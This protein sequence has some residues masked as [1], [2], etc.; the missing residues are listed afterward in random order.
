ML[1]GLIALLALGLS[2]PS[3]AQNALRY[4]RAGG[5]GDGSSWPAATGSLQGAIDAVAAAGGGQVWVAAGTYKPTSNPTDRDASFRMKNG[6]TIYGGFPAGGDPTLNNRN[7][8][9]NPTI[10]SGDIDNDGTLSGNSYHIFA[11]V[12][13]ANLDNTAVLDGFT[14]KGGM[15]MDQM[16]IIRAE[17]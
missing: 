5:T 15:R 6:V 14:L 17:R 13:T 7:W 1:L 8:Q 16:R 3:R 12:G 10:L 2:L 9:A 4:V 11:N